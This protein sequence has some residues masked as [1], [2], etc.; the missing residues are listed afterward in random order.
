[1]SLLHRLREL[2]S[3]FCAQQCSAGRIP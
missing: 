3:G 2:I 1:M